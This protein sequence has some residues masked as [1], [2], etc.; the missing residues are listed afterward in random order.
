MAI[1]TRAG[2]GSALTHPELDGNFTDLDGRATAVAARVTV[3]EDRTL[4][5]Y[6][7]E[8]HND[9]GTSQAL[10]K[11]V[12]LKL[13]NDSAG[14]FTDTSNKIPGRGDIW[15]ATLDQF[16]FDNAGLIVG[17]TITM[18]FDMIITTGVANTDIHMRLDAAIGGVGPFSLNLA[19]FS[20]KNVDDHAVT[21]IMELHAGSLDIINFPMEVVL[22]S[23]STNTSVVNVGHYVKYMLQNPEII[24]A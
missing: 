2:K 16:E 22:V 14:E 23:D 6:G 5:M 18:R 9:T 12:D 10:T 3:I 13:T 20:F 1:T 11:D 8:D 15:N 19:V 21:A 4:W 17:D 24:N 7:Y